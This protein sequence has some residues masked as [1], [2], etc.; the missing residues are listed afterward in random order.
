MVCCIGAVLPDAAG[1][2]APGDDPCPSFSEE[3]GGEGKAMEDVSANC[4]RDRSGGGFLLLAPEDNVLICVKSVRQGSVAEID[5]VAVTLRDA[6]ELGHKVA[7]VPLAPGDKV[8]RYG[9]PIGRM[10]ASAAPG[11]H[12]HHHNLASDYLPAHGR[13]AVRKEAGE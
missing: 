4:A 13:D 6:V 12:V 5:G 3:I 2:R 1:G 11:D 10:T 8:L 9:F 7:R